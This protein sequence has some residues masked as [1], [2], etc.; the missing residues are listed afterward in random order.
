[1]LPNVRTASIQK[2][3]HPLIGTVVAQLL[4]VAF[5]DDALRPAVEHHHAVRDA[6]DAR[7]LVRDDDDRRAK[8]LADLQD[9]FVEPQRRSARA[10]VFE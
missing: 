4:R 5:R 8:G 6:E 10:G 2:L 3:P 7:E 1:M 9:Q